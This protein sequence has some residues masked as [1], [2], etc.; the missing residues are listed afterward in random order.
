VPVEVN[1]ELEKRLH[2]EK[3]IWLTTVNADGQPQPA[4]VWYLWDNG[5]FLI[6]SQP[7][8]QKLRNIARNPKVSINF[9]HIDDYGEAGLMVV[10][11]EAKVDPN[12]PASNTIPRYLEKYRNGIADINMTPES[13]ASSFSVAFR[14][15][16][17]RV[18]AE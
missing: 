11:G 9:K 7:T 15:T 5:T 13:L 4:P 3:T 6:Y 14:V 16:P 2:E 8:A 18:R 17:T 12:A 10:L 1:P